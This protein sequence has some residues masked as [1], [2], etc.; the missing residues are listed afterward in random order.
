MGEIRQV[1]VAP[2]LAALMGVAIPERNEGRPA[3]GMLAWTEEQQANTWYALAS[4]RLALTNA[5]LSGIGGS[6]PR[7]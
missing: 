6:R 2:T 5:H 3:E 7:P 1:D 4:Q